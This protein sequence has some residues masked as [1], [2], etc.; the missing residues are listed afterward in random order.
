MI[1]QYYRHLLDIV[2]GVL[3]R[4]QEVASSPDLTKVPS[5][6]KEGLWNQLDPGLAPE[7]WVSTA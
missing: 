2:A 7:M 4:R 6:S 3:Y 1:G 5:H